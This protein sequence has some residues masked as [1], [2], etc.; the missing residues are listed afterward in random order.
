MPRPSPPP[1]PFATSFPR[2]PHPEGHL[3]LRLT[4]EGQGGQRAH[5]FS[6][7]TGA[8]VWGLCVYAHGGQRSTLG[9]VLQLSTFCFLVCL[10]LCACTCVQCLYICVC[11]HWEAG[12]QSR[13]SP[14]ALYLCSIQASQWTQSWLPLLVWGLLST[15]WALELELDGHT[16]L[17]FAWVLGIW[18]L[19]SKRSPYWPV[20]STT[21]HFEAGSLT[22]LELTNSA[23][24]MGQGSTCPHAQSYK[25]VP[26]HQ[27]CVCRLWGLN[28]GAHVCTARTFV[29]TVPSFRELDSEHI[30]E[31][32]HRFFSWGHLFAETS[33]VIS[34]FPSAPYRRSSHVHTVASDSR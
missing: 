23:K 4:A 24:Q 28:T 12:D 9:C 19:C 30:Y 27:A 16:H 6:M 13:G 25:C 32:T 10:C 29:S 15:F 17:A 8:R 11:I 21:V 3:S 7:H 5:A 34:H 18:I 22:G 33:C 26:Q 1:H 31:A 20:L 2:V 14:T